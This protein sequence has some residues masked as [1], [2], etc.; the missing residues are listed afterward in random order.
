MPLRR[1]YHGTSKE[2]AA[3]ILERGVDLNAPRSHDVGDFGWGFYITQNLVRAQQ[4]GSVILEVEVDLSLFAY[5]PNPYFCEGLTPTQPQTPPERL[6]HSLAFDHEGRMKTVHQGL[7][8]SDT[9]ARVIREEFLQ[10]GYLGIT[11]DRDDKETVVFDASTIVVK[12]V[13]SGD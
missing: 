3:E 4:Y 9:V 11:T 2:R 8:G 13:H 6:F 12:K 10:H 7:S 5:V 1:F